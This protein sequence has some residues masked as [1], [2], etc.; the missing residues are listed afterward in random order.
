[1]KQAVILHGMIDTHIVFIKPSGEDTQ[2]Q[3]L[4]MDVVKM[5]DDDEN[6]GSDGLG[7]VSHDRTGD[8]TA[9]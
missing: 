8:H 5:P 3:S 9:G 4:K 6:R 2:I 7:A 1:M